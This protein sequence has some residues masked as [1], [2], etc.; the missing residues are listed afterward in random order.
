[1]GMLTIAFTAMSAAAWP[2]ERATFE[3]GGSVLKIEIL[4]DD[5][6]HFELTIQPGVPDG[7]IDTSPMVDK[8]DYDGPTAPISRESGVIETKNLRIEVNAET[9]GITVSQRERP[10]QRRIVGFGGAQLGGADAV[11]SIDAP[12]MTHAY[13]LGEQFFDPPSANANWVGRQRTPGCKFGNRQ[14]PYLGGAVGN[15]TFPILY[16]MGEGNIC[17][18]VF[19]DD[20]RAQTWDL[21]TQPWQVKTASPVLRWYLLDGPD[22]P[23]LRRDYMELVG[24][25]PVPPK[26]AFGLWVSEYGFEDWAEMESKLES[27]RKHN[28]PVDGFVLD[29]QWFGGLEPGGEKSKMGCLEWDRKRFP[30]PHAKLHALAKK[31]GVGVVVIEESYISRGLPEHR[32]LA[33]KGYLV[34]SGNSEPIFLKSWWGHGGMLDW[35]NPA[36]ADYWHDTKRQAL[37]VDGVLGHWTDL[38]EPEDYSA[39]GVY[40]GD[41]RHADA[42]N[43][44]NLSWSESIARGY[45][46]NKSKRRPWILSRSGTSGIQ[47]H[48][49]AMWSG[50]TGS[51][52]ASLTEQANVQTNMSLSGIDYFGSDIGGFHRSAIDGDVDDLYTKWFAD[53]ALTDVPVRPHTSN[54]KNQHETAPDRIGDMASNLANIRL[55]YE[56]IPYLYSLA[57][58]AN[59][60]GDPVFPPLFYFYTDNQRARDNCVQ[61]MIG[62]SLMVVLNH[63]YGEKR[64]YSET[65]VGTWFEWYH[66]TQIVSTD[67]LSGSHPPYI[68]G[69][70]RLP[71][72]ARAGAIIPMM[73]VDDQTMNALGMRKDGSRRDELIVRVFAGGS[74]SFTLYEDDGETVAYQRG[75]VRSTTL[76][77]ESTDDGVT[78][79]IAPSK[80]TYKGA[81]EKRANVVRLT[82]DG[83]PQC[84]GVNLN[85]KALKRFRSAAE[86]DKAA[87]GWCQ[88]E[89]FV[90]L[91][92]T[93]VM[94]V[95]KKKSLA[96]A[97][98]SD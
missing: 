54:R 5:L 18:A 90:I 35:L 74:S 66:D 67:G 14:V 38:G 55:R 8:K 30:R 27:L 11:L 76:E 75:E 3:A 34:G 89:R 48:G 78:V 57:H 85:G 65:P 84:A 2:V 12:D 87:E 81:I 33:K 4:D 44:Y 60:L 37:V 97:L 53:S 96:F 58:R 1:M 91:A 79:T 95:T 52:M 41:M 13:G 59:R 82:T 31:S 61:K 43:L 32:N 28:F 64:Q 73:Y 56:L 21:T 72:F 50:D 42:H 62:D 22:L 7:P 40:N 9:L 92:K 86:L 69:R 98:T 88:P 26:K 51:N 47:R 77:Q 36:A 29:L 25:P 17:F 10:G 24:H 16:A 94:P 68:D 19:V 45:Q 80:G 70:L 6:V 20:V 49:A 63:E 46:R 93:A 83:R 23:D 39:D 71:L 15:N